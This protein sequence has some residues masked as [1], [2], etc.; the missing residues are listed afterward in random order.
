[1]A[2][3]DQIKNQ[4]KIITSFEFPQ[5]AFLNPQAFEDLGFGFG[6]LFSRSFQLRSY[7][8]ANNKFAIERLGFIWLLDDVFRR[9]NGRQAH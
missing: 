9:R 4:I 8:W 7:W 3:N 2:H 1:M 5:K 6:I